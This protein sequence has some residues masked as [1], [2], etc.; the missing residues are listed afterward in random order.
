L[1]R[2]V[3]LARAREIVLLGRQIDAEKAERWE[4]VHRVVPD[5]E[6]ESASEELIRELAEAPTIALG[7]TKSLLNRAF[8]STLEDA[9]G[10][11]AFALELSSRTK[12]FKEGLA[13]FAEKRAPRYRG[14]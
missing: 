7:L 14:R 3:G 8:D 9:L 10:G 4:L 13:A 5:D 6:L 12:D 1:A 11:E 2:L